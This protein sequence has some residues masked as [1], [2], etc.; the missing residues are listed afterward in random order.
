M[1]NLLIVW[2]LVMVKQEEQ[3]VAMCYYEICA[4]YS[5]AWFDADS[6]LCYCYEYDILGQL[7]PTTPKYLG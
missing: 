6:K 3:K 4:E 5:D 1:E 2:G 7:K